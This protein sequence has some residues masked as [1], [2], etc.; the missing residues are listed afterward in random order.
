MTARGLPGVWAALADLKAMID[1]VTDVTDEDRAE[2]HMFVAGLHK[3]G[4][5]RVFLAFD[6]L[7]PRFVRFTDTQSNWGLGNPDNLYLIAEIEESAEYVISGER[8][9]CDTFVVEVRTGI[10][11]RDDDVHSKS[12]CF[13]DADQ[14]DL[15]PDGRFTLHLGGA[16]RPGNYLPLPP[17]ATTIS[18]RA[19][20]ADWSTES[21]G[22]FMI[23][24]LG[25]PP[26]PVPRP[27]SEEMDAKFERVADIIGRLGRF[28]D[29]TA[30][31][32]RKKAPVNAF[33]PA[34]TD[35]TLAAFP[36][37][38]SS[39]AQFQLDEPDDVLVITLAKPPCRYLGFSTGHLDWYTNLDFNNRQTSLNSA[40]AHLSS[41]GVYRY[42]I[43]AEDPGIP[44]W[45]DTG[46]RSRGF[47]FFRCQGLQTPSLEQPTATLTKFHKVLE[48][49]PADEPRVSPDQRRESLKRRRLAVQRRH[50]Y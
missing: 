32:W 18:V 35:I 40:Q 15:R 34:G 44:N 23:E 1:G 46:G 24:R 41:D 25:P 30:K 20:F 9:S 47:M 21:I 13:I 37:Q 43:S 31:D 12:L 19:T 36:G 5:D 45:I 17:G 42:V 48:H 29:A 28:N 2:G 49:F 8:G 26:P 38:R 33:P 14:L 50:A 16:A 4:M 3:W 27:S 11:R 10:G 22:P 39:T 6:P 7:R